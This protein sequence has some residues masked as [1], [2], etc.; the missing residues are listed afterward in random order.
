M[1]F[2][3]VIMYVKDVSDTMNFY[4]KAFGLKCR[5]FDESGAYAE[6]ET[7]QTILAFVSEEM[8]KTSL[9]FQLNRKSKKSAGIEIGFVSED[10]QKQFEKAVESGAQSIMNPIKKPWGQVVSYVKDING[11][12]IEI[13]SPMGPQS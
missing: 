3:Y 6:M 9:S 4:E 5:F 7:G 12:I 13:C 8:I 2:G 1:R 11:C 10:V